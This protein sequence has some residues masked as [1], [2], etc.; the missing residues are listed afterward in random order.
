MSFEPAASRVKR[1]GIRSLWKALER[2]LR[3]NPAPSYLYPARGIGQITDHLRRRFLASGGELKLGCRP[4]RLRLR[5]DRHVEAL[6][7]RE[8]GDTDREIPVAAL[9]ATLPL[10]QLHDLVRL[11]AEGGAPPPF[12]LRW[13]ALRILYL[14]TARRRPSSTETYYFPEGRFLIGRVSE[15]HLY[16]P[17]LNQGELAA[18]TIE[19]PCSVGDRTWSLAEDEL[20]RQ[21]LGELESVG[22]LAPAPCDRDEWFSRHVPQVYPVYE[23]G[24][25]QRY[26]QIQARLG[27][28]DNLFPIGRPALFLHCNIDHGIAMALR[29][30]RFL[31]ER[32]DKAAW[33]TVQDAFLRYR[34]RD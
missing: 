22:I 20:A 13:R 10:D 4:L 34:I 23:K 30:A 16:S 18:L 12:D 5:Q 2:R 7:Y 21:C 8:G 26:A 6:T 33:L 11:E 3:G 24:W 14:L 17:A 1:F 32:A 31:E 28:I 29:L 19:I 27:P 9:I 25:R 15:L